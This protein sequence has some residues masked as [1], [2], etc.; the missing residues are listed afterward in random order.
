MIGGATGAAIERSL[1][2]DRTPA[3][4]A[5]TTSTVQTEPAVTPADVDLDT[6]PEPP[7]APVAPD[8]DPATT[9]D[10]TVTALAEPTGDLPLTTGTD[11]TPPSPTWTRPGLNQRYGDP[12]YGTPV[13]RVTDATGTRFNRNTYSRRQAENADGSRFLTYHGDAAY[14]V[15]DRDSA[16]LVRV[17]SIHPDAEP[18]WHPSDADL[19]RYVAGTNASAGALKLFEVN[20][21][22]GA[23]R[24][25]ADLTA[26][27]RERWPDALYISDGAEGAPSAA[28]DRYAWMVLDEN[29]D[30][31]GIVSYDLAADQILGLADASDDGPRQVLD[32]VSMTPSGERVVAGY[33]DGTWVTDADLTNERQINAKGDH[34][35][36][37]VDTDG[38]DAYV[39]IDFDDGTSA[40]AGWLVSVDLDTLV[41]T[42]LFRVYGGANTSVHVSGKGYDKPGWVIVS[43]YSCKDPGAWTCHKVMAVELAPDATVVHLAHTYNCGEEYWTE[44]HAA[45]NRSFT[46]VYFNS[47]AGSCGIDAEVYELTVPRIP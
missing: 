8:P 25:I 45:V 37:A 5:T 6:P 47:D 15:Y 18:Q 12:V 20:V 39:Y 30:V 43:T 9:I 31:I 11:A 23:E 13:R 27:V 24:T 35:D 32:W 3:A 26:R 29:E 7:T 21:A 40:D 33:H 17:L 28:G 46:R 22:S 4:A 19:V 14:N 36:I 1:R 16:E 2:A 38:G 44:T 41:R 42:R 34:S 10:P